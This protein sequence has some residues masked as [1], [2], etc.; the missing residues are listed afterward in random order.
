MVESVSKSDEKWICYSDFKKKFLQKTISGR[1][2]YAIFQ[3]GQFSTYK[4]VR[5]IKLFSSMSKKVSSNQNL[6][7]FKNNRANARKPIL[8]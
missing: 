6:Y 4:V 3:F 1:P 8:P 5:G 7:R 2:E